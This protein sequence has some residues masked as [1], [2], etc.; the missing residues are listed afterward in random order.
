MTNARVEIHCSKCA[1]SVLILELPA[2]RD[3]QA[4]TADVV[5]AVTKTGW[6]FDAGGRPVCTDHR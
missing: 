2:D 3:G 4:A 6:T 1:A 5:K